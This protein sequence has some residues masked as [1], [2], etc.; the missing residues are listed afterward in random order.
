M[1]GRTWSN[2]QKNIQTGVRQLALMLWKNGLGSMNHSS[3]SS[4]TW[5]WN[6]SE[7]P[8]GLDVTESMLASSSTAIFGVRKRT[9][10][11]TCV[12]Y[13]LSTEVTGCLKPHR[14]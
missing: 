10:I 14:L 8:F 6:L 2:L 3:N 7:L 11:W 9:I 12:T 4:C 5:L 13:Y 1:H